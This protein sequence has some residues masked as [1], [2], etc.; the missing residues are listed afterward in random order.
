M[1]GRAL[2]LRPSIRRSVLAT[3]P[4]S[5]RPHNVNEPQLHE[6]ASVWAMQGFDKTSEGVSP[7]SGVERTAECK[8]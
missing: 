4:S 1:S 8:Q 5:Q 7:W 3:I 6:A 2:L